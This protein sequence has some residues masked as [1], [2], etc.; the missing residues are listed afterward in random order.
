MFKRIDGPF[1]GEWK[2][3]SDLGGTSD[4]VIAVEV[5]PEGMFSFEQALDAYK[6][7]LVGESITRANVA[8][9]VEMHEAL[10]AYGKALERPIMDSEELLLTHEKIRKLARKMAQMEDEP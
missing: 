7:V 2:A 6:G 4:T 9:I 5:D 1:R 3:G 8:L 10:R